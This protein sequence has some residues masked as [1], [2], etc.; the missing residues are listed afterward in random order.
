MKL[1]VKLIVIN[2]LFYCKTFL[3]G[4]ENFSAE[5]LRIFNSVAKDSKI[6]GV[7]LNSASLWNIKVPEVLVTYNI[8]YPNLTDNT[9]FIN[10]SLAVVQKVLGGG[11]GFGFNQFGIKDWY[12]KNRLFFSY[13][14]QLKEIFSKLAV[15]LKFI[16]EEETYNLDDY[17]KQNPIFLRN[18]GISY[19]SVSLGGLYM[20]NELNYLGFSIDNITRPNVGIY[21]EENLPIK[22]SIGYKY[23][24]KNIEVLPTLQLEFSKVVDYVMALAF[25]YKFLLFNKKFKLSPS[26]GIGYGR[27]DYNSVNLG[28]GFYTSQISFNYGYAFS[29]LSK[30]NAGGIQAISLSYKFISQPLEEEK[31]PKKEYDKLLLEKQKLEEQLKTFTSE[32]LDSIKEQSQ[33]VTPTQSV[34][35]TTEEILLK[36]LEELEK[37]LK[38]AETKKVEEKPKSQPIQQ[39][40]TL[41]PSVHKKR[42]HTVV[43]GDTLPKLAE[44]YYGS[45]SEWRKIYEANK[46]KIIR[47]HLVPGTVLEIP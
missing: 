35:T 24:Y 12:I 11:L 39:P 19:Y 4:V 40:T 15:G 25:E 36:K 45:A 42:Y 32:K 1:L 29:P 18:K 3:Y 41:Q 27:K 9:E 13:G 14:R 7:F 26:L 43:E 34:T 47:G 31:V 46:D 44:K 16:C 20:F 33:E 21:T 28:F 5:N 37:K 6:D 22:I 17:M 8:L 2:L 10:N 38:E 23:E 30:V